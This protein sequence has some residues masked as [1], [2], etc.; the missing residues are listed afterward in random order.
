MDN[1]KWKIK[2]GNGE[3][4]LNLFKINVRAELASKFEK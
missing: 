3:E 4:K 1:G 2:N